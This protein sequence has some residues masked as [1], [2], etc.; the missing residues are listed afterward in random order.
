MSKLLERSASFSVQGNR[1]ADR[2]A[3]VCMEI[4]KELRYNFD[5]EKT[6]KLGFTENVLYEAIYC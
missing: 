3:S 6:S 4:Y 5:L 2:N 1:P